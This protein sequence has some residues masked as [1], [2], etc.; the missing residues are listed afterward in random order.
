MEFFK[1]NKPTQYS[2]IIR[3]FSYCIKIYIKI[4]QRIA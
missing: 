4:A 2:D 1:L 3:D